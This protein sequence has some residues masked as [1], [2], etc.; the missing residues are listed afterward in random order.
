MFLSTDDAMFLE[1]YQ[2]QGLLAV[3]YLTHSTTFLTGCFMITPLPKLFEKSILHFTLPVAF[4]HRMSTLSSIPYLACICSPVSHRP[5][6]GVSWLSRVHEWASQVDPRKTKPQVP[7]KSLSG[8]KITLALI[9][10]RMASE[11][12][13]NS[14]TSWTLTGGE[15]LN[16]LALSLLFQWWVTVEPLYVGRILW[17]GTSGRHWLETP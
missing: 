14:S 9:P 12:G 10:S 1:Y 16:L 8:G 3:E 4:K 2:F 15:P 17:L 6:I 13:T 7:H 11:L 5:G